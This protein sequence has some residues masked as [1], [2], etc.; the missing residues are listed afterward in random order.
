LLL[1]DIVMPGLHGHEAR[2]AAPGP[3]TRAEGALYVGVCPG[4]GPA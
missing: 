2:G 3:A 4:S 1:T